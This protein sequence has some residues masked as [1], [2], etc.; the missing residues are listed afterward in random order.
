MVLN[1][2]AC[3]NIFSVVGNDYEST[4]RVVPARPLLVKINGAFQVPDWGII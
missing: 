1:H 3:L 2:P 4:W